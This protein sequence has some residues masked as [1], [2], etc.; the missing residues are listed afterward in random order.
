M[1]IYFLWA[2]SLCFFFSISIYAQEENPLEKIKELTTTTQQLKALGDAL[3]KNQMAQ[4]ALLYSYARAYDSI[5]KIDQSEEALINAINFNGNAHYANEDYDKAIEYYIQAIPL[6]EQKEVSMM[7]SLVYNNLAGCYRVSNDFPNTEKYFNKAL[8]IG[9]QL[10][11]KKW[12]ANISNNLAVVYMDNQLYEKADAKYQV[13]IDIYAQVKDTLMMGITYMNQGNSRISSKDYAEAID[14]YTKAQEYVPYKMVPLLH[15]VSQTGIGIALTGLDQFN[16]AKPYLDK[17]AE[18]AKTI[19]HSEQL[20]ESYSALSDYYSKTKDYK[21]AFELSAVSQQLRDS[22]KTTEE[23]K[24][25]SDALAKYE[26]EKKDLQ[27]Q[28]LAFEKEKETRHKER[29]IFLS[30]VAILLASF[31]GFFSMKN[32][33]KNKLLASQ[34]QTLETTL[35]QKDVLLKEIHH[36]VK[37]NLQVISSLLSLQQRQLNDPKASQAIQV[38]RDRVKAMSLI[39]QNLYQDTNLIGVEAD[40]YINN[41]AHSLVNTYKTEDKEIAIHID[42]SAIKLDIDTIIPLGLIINELISN[43]LKYA[44]MDQASGE[45]SISL[46]EEGQALHL[47]V[48]DNGI[49]LPEDFSV[50]NNTS[51]GYRLIKA[52][53][54]KLKATL[55]VTSKKGNTSISIAIRDYKL[56]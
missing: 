43:S 3:N 53:S 19:N 36:R 32:R 15:A 25:L 45:I 47:K 30:L 37:N 28:K 21:N 24:N 14:R 8:E 10:D 27:L 41:L 42:V 13:A 29:F 55:Q 56:N 11:D 18:I 35:S 2:Y 33:S 49:G 22:I 17:G 34:K 40:Q 48:T 12:V 4:P 38:G 26:G 31:I 1:R 39:H 5:A 44:F 52:F 16:E 23:N 9:T 50:E 20:M 51:L 46:K 7:L 6:L 54:D